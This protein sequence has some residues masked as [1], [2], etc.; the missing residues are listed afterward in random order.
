M[1][2]AQKQFLDVFEKLFT[3]TIADKIHFFEAL[4]FYFTISSRRIGAD[5]KT[6]DTEK[7]AAF[8]WLNEV[9]HRI[10]NILYGLQ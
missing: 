4:L 2:E 9:T 8:K 1:N 10:W 7:V 6:T 5:D 3:L